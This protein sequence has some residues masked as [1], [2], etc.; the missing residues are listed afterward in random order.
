M[1]AITTL[2]RNI[3]LLCCLLLAGC[4]GFQVRGAVVTGPEGRAAAAALQNIAAD[5]DRCKCFEA[6]VTVNLA[7]SSWGGNRA[8]SF[9]GYLQ[10]MAPSYLKFI[11]VNPFGQPPLIVAMDN[12]R[13]QTVLVPEAKVFI[14]DVG[15]KTFS[16]YAPP[17]LN[18]GDLFALL[19]GQV[20]IG[21]GV[22]RAIRESE[23][24]GTYWF[25]LRGSEQRGRVHLLFDTRAEVIRRYVVADRFD[26]ILVDV[27]Y[28][29]YKDTDGCRLPGRVR[30]ESPTQ[31]GRLDMLTSDILL[32]KELP[33]AL[34]SH[35]PPPPGFESII[36]D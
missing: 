1:T 26:K 3:P 28:A 23:T 27:S 10:T 13:F 18:P 25:E 22:I 30:I 24:V 2:G 7:I 17:G 6:E 14:G 15:A 32:C 35:V 29:D 12:K 8:A 5:H 20:G 33:T 11:G 19:S 4:A 31:N 9:S 36:V 16:K 34:F 21:D